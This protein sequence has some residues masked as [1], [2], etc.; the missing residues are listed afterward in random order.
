MTSCT[1]SLI[2]KWGVRFSNNVL[3]LVIF[4]GLR[5]VQSEVVDEEYARLPML[6]PGHPRVG[7]DLCRLLPGRSGYDDPV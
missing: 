7:N 1:P 3:G 2:Q 5:A 6:V 4:N